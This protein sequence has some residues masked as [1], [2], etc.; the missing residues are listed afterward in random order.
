MLFL[1]TIPFGFIILLQFCQYKKY[2]KIN[3]ENF[4]AMT[5][6]TLETVSTEPTFLK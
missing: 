5:K 4:I 1:Y 3:L 6:L 2:D